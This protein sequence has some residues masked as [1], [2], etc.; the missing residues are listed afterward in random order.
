MSPVPR[1]P[2][3]GGLAEQLVERDLGAVS[4]GS[5]SAP[6]GRA[7]A[8]RRGGPSWPP[9]TAARPRRRCS[10]R[11]CDDPD[12]RG[13]QPGIEVEGLGGPGPGGRCSLRGSC[14][15]CAAVLTTLAP[16][17]PAAARRAGAARGRCRA[18]GGVALTFD[19]GPHPE[20]TPAML[21]I[22][23]AAGAQR[24]VLPGRRAGRSAGRRSRR[25]SR[26]QGHLVAL[27]GYRH[28]LQLRLRAAR[29]SP[30]TW[31]AARPRSRTRP[32]RRSAGTARRTGST[33]PPGSTAARERGFGPLLWSRWGK[34]WRKFT[35]P[36]RIA[37]RATRRA[38]GRRRDSP[39]RCGFLQ[40]PQFLSD[41][42]PRRFLRSS[43]S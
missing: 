35:T 36:A 11:W 20:G 22:L 27:H 7:S 1:A 6:A 2:M 13:R 8:Y 28:R 5:A 34:D 15:V 21:E 12:R 26:P 17:L 30:T 32:G 31:R 4:R 19:D 38:G 40:R 37:A 3:N 14:P 16:V 41:A 43:T 33:A 24:D 18:P 9:P 23:A 10:R 29:S 42:L 25:G 39:A